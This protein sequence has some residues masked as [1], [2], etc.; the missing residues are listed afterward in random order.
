[1]ADSSSDRG[2]AMC[3]QMFWSDGQAAIAA[4]DACVR[5][6]NSTSTA[7]SQCRFIPFHDGGSGQ[8]S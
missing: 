7:G 1:M 6:G 2:A 3:C 5:Q 8:I 4:S